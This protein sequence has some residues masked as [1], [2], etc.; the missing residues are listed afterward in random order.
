MIFP[1]SHQLDS[2]RKLEA[3]SCAEGPGKNYLVQHSAGGFP[4][5]MI[6]NGDAWPGMIA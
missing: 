3:T 4:L 1:R 5:A 2:V 6:R